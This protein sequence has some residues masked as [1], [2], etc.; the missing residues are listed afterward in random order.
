MQPDSGERLPSSFLDEGSEGASA[1]PSGNPERGKPSCETDMRMM[2]GANIPLCVWNI[3][4][5]PP[6]L[7]GQNPCPERHFVMKSLISV[8]KRLSLNPDNR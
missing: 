1:A 8:S 4:F 7:A 3:L 5:L 2:L 6:Q